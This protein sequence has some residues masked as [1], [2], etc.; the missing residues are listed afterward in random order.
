MDILGAHVCSLLACAI[1][2]ALLQSSSPERLP[3]SEPASENSP[4]D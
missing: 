2:I 1:T 3:T 4:P